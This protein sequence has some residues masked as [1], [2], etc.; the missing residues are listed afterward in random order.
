MYRV[1]VFRG[2][3]KE[4]YWHVV[5]SNGKI[6]CSGG[7]GFKRRSSITKIVDKL[8]AANPKVIR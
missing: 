2:V 8:F 1:K 5:A 3:N 7:E 4:W 6:V